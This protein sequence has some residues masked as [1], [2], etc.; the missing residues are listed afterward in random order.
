[1]YPA[2]SFRQTDDLPLS[3]RGPQRTQRKNLVHHPI[4]SVFSVVLC[5]LC[6]LQMS[7][8]FFIPLDSK[9]AKRDKLEYKQ[10]RGRSSSSSR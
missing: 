6:G 9:H 4:S 7:A 5:V 1:M 10:K 3:H 8:R 2:V